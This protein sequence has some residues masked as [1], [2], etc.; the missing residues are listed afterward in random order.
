MFVV[1]RVFCCVQVVVYSVLIVV[2]CLV[3]VCLFVD[4]FVRSFVCLPVCS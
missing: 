4:P 2:C 1:R 3:F